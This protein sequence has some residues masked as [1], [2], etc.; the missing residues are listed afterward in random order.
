MS[1]YIHIALIGAILLFGLAFHLRNGQFVTLDYYA[2]NV[3]LPL[4][5]W[6][7]IW[8][9][10][11]VGLGLLA[12][13]PVLLRIR[14]DNSRLRRALRRMEADAEKARTAAAGNPP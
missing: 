2:D 9:A 4:S 5:L 6:V 11:G 13:L 14:R 12:M 7:F 8:V 3:T 10:A 1:R